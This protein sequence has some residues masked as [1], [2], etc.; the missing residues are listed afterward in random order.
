VI[1]MTEESK[2]KKHFQSL[3]L[4]EHIEQLLH[5][6]MPKH[7][8]A[9]KV[10]TA[11]KAHSLNKQVFNVLISFCHQSIGVLRL[12]T[13]ISLAKRWERLGIDTVEKA[14]EQARYEHEIISTFESGISAKV[15]F[16]EFDFDFDVMV[17]GLSEVLI[18]KSVLTSAIKTK[19]TK[20]AFLYSFS[21]VD[22]QKVV[23]MAIDAENRLTDE[24]LQ[25]TAKDYY[26][27]LNSHNRNA[28]F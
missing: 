7:T 9:M 5:F 1:D 28:H 10:L 13:I 11:Y 23:M 16:K 20:V 12:E 6:D 15:G 3:D 2:V 17:A 27:L 22:M 26:R 14:M 8:T 18:P 4:E 25:K 21:P 19:I 24:R